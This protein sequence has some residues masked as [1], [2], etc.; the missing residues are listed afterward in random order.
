MASIKISDLHPAGS[1][2]FMDSENF[3]SELTDSELII[4]SGGKI[5]VPT[6]VAVTLAVFV[7]SAAQG[8]GEEIG[9]GIGR[10]V[11]RGVSKGIR[12]VSGLF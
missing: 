10:G 2:L 7:V 6:P 8:A 12:W 9:R 11:I 5:S 3:L 1:D 4:L